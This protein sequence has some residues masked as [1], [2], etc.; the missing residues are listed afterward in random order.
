VLH[1]TAAVTEH[2]RLK[3]R[4][5]LSHAMQA[6]LARMPAVTGIGARRRHIEGRL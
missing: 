4:T 3:R 2:A 1:S 6:T 5:L